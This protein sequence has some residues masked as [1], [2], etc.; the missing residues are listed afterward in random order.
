MRCRPLKWSKLAAILIAAL[1][2]AASEAAAAALASTWKM[3]HLAA[4]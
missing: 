1:V 3:A 4:A 2:T